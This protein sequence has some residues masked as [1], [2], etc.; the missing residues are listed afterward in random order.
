MLRE[1]LSSISVADLFDP[2]FNPP[3]FNFIDTF[4]QWFWILNLQLHLS[5]LWTVLRSIAN[6]RSFSSSPKDSSTSCILIVKLWKQSQKTCFLCSLFR[7]TVQSVAVF[8]VVRSPW[9]WRGCRRWGPSQRRTGGRTSC[10]SADSAGARWRETRRSAAPRENCPSPLKDSVKPRYNIVVLRS[11][12]QAWI[13]LLLQ[14]FST[15]FLLIRGKIK[16]IIWSIRDA[17]HSKIFI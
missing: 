8:V 14:T 17:K 6:S 4:S 10:S 2:Y 11:H 12:F 16:C 7:C 13:Y 1:K 9:T 5:I 15:V 3:W